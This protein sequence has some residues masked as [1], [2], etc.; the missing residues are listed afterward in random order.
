[1][2]ALGL[3]A[4]CREQQGRL[5]AAWRAYRETTQRADAT[6]DARG[7]FSRQRAASLEP[8]LPKIAVRVARP[9]PGLEIRQDGERLADGASEVVAE[10]GPHEI[11]ISAPGHVTQRIRVLAKEGA[12][13]TVEV[14]DLAPLAAPEPS[15]L[16]AA[17]KPEPSRFGPRLP[18]AIVSGGIGLAALG[19][20]I[21]FGVTALNRNLESSTIYDT[22]KAPGAPAGACA[23]GA[24]ARSSAFSAATAS[25][26]G[27]SVA[28][29]GL[30]ASAVLLLVPRAK[31]PEAAAKVGLSVT[32]L[33]GA[34]GGGALVRGQF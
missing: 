22:C 27:F 4:A 32:P 5:V 7:D 21:G 6:H 9:A 24:D 16:P 13:V 26:V 18:A 3:L 15:L 19:V 12:V 20:G 2:S 25:T 30:A 34:Q 33:A 31:A 23:K 8:R 10:A 29:V 1:M 28:A 11:A 14:P 17:P